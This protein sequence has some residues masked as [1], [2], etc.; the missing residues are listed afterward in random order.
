MKRPTGTLLEVP[1]GVVTVMG[2][3]PVPGGL[4]TV[5]CVLEL[6]TMVASAMPKRTP[7]APASPVPLML[8]VV[9]P[10]VPPPPG[11]M[12]VTAGRGVV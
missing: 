12:P 2:T 3:V 1:A 7:V 11:E 8:T 9:P 6:A 5:I 4:V 10:E